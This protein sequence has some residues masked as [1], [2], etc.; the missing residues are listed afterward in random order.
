MPMCS[1]LKSVIWEGGARN[2]IAA[3]LAHEISRK[4]ECRK[5]KDTETVLSLD[6]VNIDSQ[7]GAKS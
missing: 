6:E 5:V 3:V 2:E 1:S 7:T 4:I